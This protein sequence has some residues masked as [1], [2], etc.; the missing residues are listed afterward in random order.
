MPIVWR[1]V[2]VPVPL[3]LI[4]PLEKLPVLWSIVRLISDLRL[5]TDAAKV[6]DDLVFQY[7]NKP[8]SLR[9]S[10]FKVFVR[11]QS[12]EKSLLHCILRNDIVAQSED[13]VFEKI[14]A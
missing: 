3:P 1:I 6:V 12:R 11:F 5:T 10:S 13:G 2:V 14:V 9:T 4:R 7:S 8:G